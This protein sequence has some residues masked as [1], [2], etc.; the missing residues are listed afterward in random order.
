MKA[1]LLILFFLTLTLTK[2]LKLT[3]NEEIVEDVIHEFKDFG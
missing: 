1:P 2:E 3:V